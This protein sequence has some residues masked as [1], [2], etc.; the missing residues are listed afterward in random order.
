MPT[1]RIRII[2]HEPVPQSGSFE[3]RF[4]DGRESKFFYFDDILARHLRP[5]ILTSEAALEQAKAF[6]RAEQDKGGKIKFDRE[7]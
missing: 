5:D 6:A 3:V 2:R 7:L 4:A 1:S